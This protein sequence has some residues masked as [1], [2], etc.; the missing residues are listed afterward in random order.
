MCMDEEYML[1]LWIFFKFWHAS[2]HLWLAYV[3]NFII[4][5]VLFTVCYVGACVEWLIFLPIIVSLIYKTNCLY[6]HN[7]WMFQ[8][9][10]MSCHRAVVVATRMSSSVRTRASV[11]RAPGDVTETRT[12]SLRR[13]RWIARWS[14]CLSNCILF[15][16][17]SKSSSLYLHTLLYNIS[18]LSSP[19]PKNLKL[20]K[21]VCLLRKLKY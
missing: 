21:F 18:P 5:F 11:F 20:H 3:S 13:M 12:A 6:L 7:C 1:I 9:I 16:A 10:H 19:H 2:Q 17:N 14:V 8:A 4:I 15:P